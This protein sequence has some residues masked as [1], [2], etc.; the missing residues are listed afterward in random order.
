MSA[1]RLSIII[2]AY[3]EAA[4]LPATLARIGE[5]FATNDP[6]PEV[7]VID[8]GSLDG[9]GEVALRFANQ[10]LDLRI[11]HEPD[12][13][14]KGYAVRRGMLAAQGEL[15]LMCDA[16]LSTPIEELA[17]LTPWIERGYDVVIGS[18]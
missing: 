8:D 16:D 7:L 14:G 11:L 9:T 6:C 13:R 4:R 12:N 15:R 5:Y 2:P 3:N 1:A 18:R 17:K 10:T